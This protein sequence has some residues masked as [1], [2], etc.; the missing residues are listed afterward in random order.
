VQLAKKGLFWVRDY[1][2]AEVG[3]RIGT[4]AKV[5]VFV[6]FCGGVMCSKLNDEIDNCV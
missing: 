1:E 6:M 3:K 5:D 4:T 2:D